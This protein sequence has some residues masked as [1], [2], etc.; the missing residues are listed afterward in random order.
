M[1]NSTSLNPS[2]KSL[3]Y[4]STSQQHHRDLIIFDAMQDLNRQRK[5]K[6]GKKKSRRHATSRN[7][8]RLPKQ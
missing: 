5:K 1:G 6:H 8:S 4:D 3:P 2:V 7:V